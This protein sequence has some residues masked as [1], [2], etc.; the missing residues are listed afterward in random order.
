MFSVALLLLLAAGSRVKCEQLTQPKSETV[1]PGQRLTITC[2]VTYSLSTSWTG[3]IRQPAG[4]GLEWI[5]S[6]YTGEAAYKDSLKNKFSIDL[7][8]SSKTVTLI[9]QNMQPDDTG[10]YYCAKAGAAYSYGYFD[11]WGKGTQVTVTSATSTAPTVFPLVPCGTESGEMVTL[12]CLATGFN[13][14]AV[15]FSWTKGG[16]ALTDFIQYPAVQKG[17]VYTGVSQVRVR[18]QDWNAQQNL[19][20]AVTHAA[21]NAQT[22]VT[23]PPPTFKQNPT[24]KV[25]SSSSD[26]DGTYT[27][28]CFAKEFAPK[29]H[30]LKWLKN[31]ADITS[32]IDLTETVSESK[33]AAGKT[34]YNAASFLTVNSTGLNDQTKFMCLFTGGEDASLNKTVA[35]KDNTP[36]FKPCS[37][38][39]VK[40]QIFGPKTQD[41]LFNKKGTITC[42]VMTENKNL[43]ISWEDEEGNDMESKPITPVNG[44]QNAYKS[45]LDI[46]YDEWT[47][48]VKRFCVVHHQDLIEPLREPYERDFGGNPQRPSV[49]ML[50][51]LEQTNKAEVTLTCFVKD[52]FP[53]EVFVSW[54]V[55]DEE[56][57]SSYAFNTTEPIENNG[58]YS[59]YGQLFVSLE[60]WQRDDA[61]Y[62]CV[63]Y[64]ESVVNTTRAIVR[65]IGY[66]TFDK[67]RIDLNMNINQDSKCSA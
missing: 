31:G 12:G 44:M 4:K 29:K 5:G 10:M 38:S 47:R 40:A 28:S 39:D 48:G 41:M 23:P 20:C 57:D 52:F 2:Q 63:V 51:P 19:Q 37:T 24:V 15:T 50:P 14:P 64:H 1:Q 26:E 54:L 32:T 27:A 16:A 58:F 13:P 42:K 6:R 21:G 9:G 35:Y 8:T 17:N 49:F 59:A 3:W 7:D 11:Y 53:K 46:T 22:I 65:S 67:N 43:Y 66:R 62:S 34:V 45:E 55:D 56:A 61:V 60:Q 36:D 30:N 33:N 18:R 25:F